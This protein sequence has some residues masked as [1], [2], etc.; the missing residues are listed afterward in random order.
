[1]SIAIITD[2]LIRLRASER[3]TSYLLTTV[4]VSDMSS[5]STADESRRSTAS[6]AAAGAVAGGGAYLLGYASTY[7]LASAP[8]RESLART[9]VE[10]V[11]GEPATWKMV[12]WVFYSAHF[13][14]TVIPGLFGSSRTVDLVDALDAVPALLYL[15]PPVV[16]VAAGAVLARWAGASDIRDGATTGVAVAAGY[17][18]LAAGGASLFVVVVG[19]AVVRPDLIP[20]AAVAGV[21]YPVVFGGLGGVVGALATGRGRPSRPSA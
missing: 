4:V 3:A 8:V 20:A 9:L 1:V 12:G 5:P 14:E 6:T 13:V 15:L 11:T 10:F 21:A 19:D 17:F 18:P 16:L 7:L 2:C